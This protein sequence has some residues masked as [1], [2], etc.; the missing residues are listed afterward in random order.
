MTSDAEP[1]AAD[2]DRIVTI[3]SRVVQTQEHFNDICMRVRTLYATVIAAIIASYGVLIENS[4]QS[5]AL[6]KVEIDAVVPMTLAASLAA[7][8][9][10]FVDRHWYHSLLLGAVAQGAEIESKW[11]HKIPELQLGSKILE[12]SPVSLDSRPVAYL[13]AR[14]FVRDP[15]LRSE[16]KVHSDAKIEIF[17]KPV[18]RLMLLAFLLS[19]LFGGIE[20]FDK[21]LFRL[22]QEA[23]WSTG[24]G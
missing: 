7:Y 22:A 10:Y 1:S 21:S 8:L 14:M 5:I 24:P 12:K 4:K 11:A 19:G 16:R 3:W 9:F 17:Y 18:A 2:L 23:L 20:Y 6:D 13:F 15:R